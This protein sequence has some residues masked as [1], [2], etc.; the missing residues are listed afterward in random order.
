VAVTSTWSSWKGISSWNVFAVRSDANAAP[1][2]DEILQIV[3]TDSDCAVP[4][5]M[6]DEKTA[7]NESPDRFMAE[8]KSV[9]DLLNG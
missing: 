5:P 9:G 1:F 3:F 8:L 7:I 2:G 6:S 4:D